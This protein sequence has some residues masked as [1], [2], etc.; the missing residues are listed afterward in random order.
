MKMLDYAQSFSGSYWE[1]ESLSKRSEICEDQRAGSHSSKQAIV[2]KDS[3]IMPITVKTLPL[4][5]SQE[6]LAENNQSYQP[7]VVLT[8]TCGWV[9]GF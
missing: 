8:A 5:N 7:K 1:T 9:T 2:M 6:S 3:A 4:R